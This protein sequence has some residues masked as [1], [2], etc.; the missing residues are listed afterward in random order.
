MNFKLNHILLPLACLF[1]HVAAYADTATCEEPAYDQ[2]TDP[3]CNPNAGGGRGHG[4]GGGE[5]PCSFNYNLAMKACKTEKP[6]SK[7]A[8]CSQT[9]SAN[10]AKCLKSTAP[11]ASP[12]AGDT[13]ICGPKGCP[14][15]L[16]APTKPK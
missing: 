1:V 8:K 15:T 2:I 16:K 11:P 12:S 10:L 3:G 7:E 6:A 5:N 4:I 9:A 14:D 13:G